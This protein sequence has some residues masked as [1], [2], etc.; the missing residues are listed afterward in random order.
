MAGHVFSNIIS[1]A[2]SLISIILIVIVVIAGSHPHLLT[3]FYFLKINIQWLDVP[4]KLSNATILNDLYI[5]TGTDWVGRGATKGSLGIGDSYTVGLLAAC[6]E[7]G[8]KQNCTSPKIGFHFNPVSDLHLQKTALQ[9]SFPSGLLSATNSYKS[10][11]PFMGGAYYASV[12]LLFLA[13]ITGCFASR[14]A[15]VGIFSAVLA[16]LASVLLLAASITEPIIFSKLANEINS[17][18]RKNGID[19]SF[20]SKTIVVSFIATFL[21]LAVSLI[22]VFRSRSARQRRPRAPRSNSGTRKLQLSTRDIEPEK[23]QAAASRK[24]PFSAVLQRIPT[25]GAARY[26]QI[27]RQPKVVATGAHSRRGSADDDREL[28]FQADGVQGNVI[29]EHDE[30][31]EP[32]GYAHDGP[33]GIQMQSVGGRAT[34]DINLA[35]E[36]FSRGA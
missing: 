30:E 27:E 36:P 8:H 31:H 16:F 10:I 26:T 22:L 19:A 4:S 5:L 14:K 28:L 11:S 25:F 20:G 18:F 6:S 33:R 13:M 9:G 23:G 1:F 29:H 12:V 7:Y 2:L 35:Y 32:Q 15:A 21:A 17:A 34:R 24:T 3:D